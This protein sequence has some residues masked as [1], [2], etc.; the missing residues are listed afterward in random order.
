MRERKY[1]AWDKHN[2]VWVGPYTLKQLAD[3]DAFSYDRE[4]H[5]I[6]S[7]WECFEWVEYI[8]RKDRKG[9]EIF[10]SD[11]VLINHPQDLTGDLTNAVGEVF[12]WDEEGGWYH[13][14]G[15]GRPPK[16]MWKYVEVIGNRYEHPELIEQKRYKDGAEATR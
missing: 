3:E 5:A 2:K 16:R 11:I 1:K 9:Q 13:G 12:W 6:C 10:E 14:N 4:V 8:G 7:K 15:N